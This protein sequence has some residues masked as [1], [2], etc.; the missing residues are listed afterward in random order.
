MKKNFEQIIIILFLFSIFFLVS[1]LVNNTIL[2]NVIKI[3]LITISLII[4]ILSTLIIFLLLKLFYFN[5]LKRIT[6]E[7]KEVL[8]NPLYEIKEIKRRFIFS[9]LIKLIKE[10]QE[11]NKIIIRNILNLNEVLEN[12]EI[13]IKQL[14]EEYVNQNNRLEKYI[15][16]LKNMDYNILTRLN[17]EEIQLSKNYEKIEMLKEFVGEKIK[18]ITEIITIINNIQ[19]INNEIIDKKGN[20]EKNREEIKSEIEEQ[21]KLILNLL[22]DLEVSNNILQQID[23]LITNIGIEISKLEIKEGGILSLI[24]EIKNSNNELSEKFDIIKNNSILLKSGYLN[25]K[26]NFKDE[27]EKEIIEIKSE[28]EIKKIIEDLTEKNKNLLNELNNNFD[29]IDNVLENTLFTTNEINYLK[30]EVN[31]FFKNIDLYIKDTKNM[32]ELT[33]LYNKLFNRFINETKKIIIIEK[34][35]ENIKELE[36]GLNN[37]LKIIIEKLKSIINKTN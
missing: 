4:S 13:R 1:F 35:Y 30:K 23:I 29:N 36:I 10:Q 16:I 5:E 28:E 12:T 26:S 6:N 22:K 27:D 21:E 11:K 25:I 8:K 33:E 24:E 14:Y 37:E 15:E 34:D 20:E 18:I 2:E 32:S 19:K 31:H 17:K 3:E 7:L 9:E